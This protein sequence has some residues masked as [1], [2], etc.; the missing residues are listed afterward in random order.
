MP[1]ITWQYNLTSTEREKIVD[2]EIRI[3]IKRGRRMERPRTRWFSQVFE[4]I[5]NR[6]N[7]WQ[8]I[9]K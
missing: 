3:R 7:S 6:E 1:L 8:E 4:Y 2:S 5:K 9:E